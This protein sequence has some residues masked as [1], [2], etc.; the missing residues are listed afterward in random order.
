M[1]TLGEK[2]LINIAHM[3]KALSEPTR[4]KIMQSL[5]DGKKSVGEIVAEVGTCQA[6]ISKHLNLLAR[7]GLL[8]RERSGTTIYYLICSP[9]VSH[10]CENICKGYEKIS[11]RA[12]N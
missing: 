7:A 8:K 3:L 6:N 1:I 5:H 11:G 4:L 12:Q 10:L 9:F 2:D